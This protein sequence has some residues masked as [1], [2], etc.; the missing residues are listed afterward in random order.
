MLAPATPREDRAGSH[1]D[2]QARS[3]RDEPAGSPRGEW[4]SLSASSAVKRIVAPVHNAIQPATQ[5]A[6]A[7]LTS[8][9]P[10]G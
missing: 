6:M 2:A 8:L 4:T 10:I 3:L 5:P 7:M 9:L 1:R